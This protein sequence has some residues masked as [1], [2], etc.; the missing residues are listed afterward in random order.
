[1]DDEQEVSSDPVLRDVIGALRQPANLGN[2]AVDRAMAE[3]RSDS[4]RARWMPHAGWAAALAASVALA[5]IGTR[6]LQRHPVAGVTFA[7]SAP[8]AGRV[9][10]I[11]DFNDWN[12]DANPLEQSR[13]QWS[14]TLKLKPGRYRYSF[15]VDGSSWQADPHTP[16]A[17]DDFGTPTSVITVPN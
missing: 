8:A 5:L 10:L 15:V 17:E 16:V 11:G 3:L 6:Q 2:G 7:L 13:S 9:A 14:V 1:V 4:R 12:P